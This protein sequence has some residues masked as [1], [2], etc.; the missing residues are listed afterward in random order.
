VKIELV[1]EAEDVVTCKA[2]LC[3]RCNVLLLSIL[4]LLS[5][6]EGQLTG[7][8]TIEKLDLRMKKR[9]SET[10]MRIY[11]EVICEGPAVVEKGVKR[12][13]GDDPKCLFCGD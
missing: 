10:R 1:S 2:W 8:R 12:W 7:I 11:F 3:S 13:L 9:S 4:T 5:S 6:N